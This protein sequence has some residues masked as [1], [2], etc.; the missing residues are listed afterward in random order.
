MDL[1]KSMISNPTYYIYKHFQE[2][3]KQVDIA[4]LEHNGDRIKYKN[5]IDTINQFES[6][7]INEFKTKDLVYIKEYTEYVA[8]DKLT[9][10][11]DKII[12][13]IEK[14]IFSNITTFFLKKSRFDV[15]QFI[16]IN[17]LYFGN[18]IMLDNLDHKHEL[19]KIEILKYVAQILRVPQISEQCPIL[20]HPHYTKFFMNYTHVENSIWLGK[21]IQDDVFYGLTN[22]QDIFIQSL[23]LKVMPSSIT[24]LTNLKNLTFRNCNLDQINML[25][26]LKQLE[27]IDFSDNLIENLPRNIFE[28]FKKL[29]HINFSFNRII[30]LDG[31]LFKGLDNLR[32]IDFS[33]NK[34]QTLHKNLFTGLNKLEI[35]KFNGNRIRHLDRYMFE[36]LR[37]LEQIFF[38][39]NNIERLLDTI[40][41]GLRKLQFIKFSNNNL[42]YIERNI[43][44]Q[45][46]SLKYIYFDSN[47]IESLDPNIFYGLVRLYALDFSKNRIRLLDNSIFNGLNNLK[48]INFESNFLENIVPSIELTNLLAVNFSNNSG[49]DLVLGESKKF[50]PVG[51]WKVIVTNE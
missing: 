23:N 22:L 13:D 27:R 16:V 39:E 41:Y 49:K 34:I 51:N 31:S 3:R 9:Y 33:N 43:F 50:I 46:Y 47:L 44:N 8:K 2:I 17:G 29:R 20:G 36:D 35:I 42:S 24:C 28:D 6:Y 11:I 7:S 1:I 26:S 15:N 30:E 45:L 4:F 12:Y 19:N 25:N 48:F 38:N 37:N 5:L 32:S 10:E 40:F 18:I 21:I 14:I